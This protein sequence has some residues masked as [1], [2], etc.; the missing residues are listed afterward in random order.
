[1][2]QVPTPRAVTPS[3]RVEVPTSVG[4]SPAV[5][6]ASSKAS[7]VYAHVPKANTMTPEA[8]RTPPVT[9][10]ASPRTPVHAGQRGPSTPSSTVTSTSATRRPDTPVYSRPLGSAFPTPV[11]GGATPLR[12]PSLPIP[13]DSNSDTESSVTPSSLHSPGPIPSSSAQPTSSHILP[14]PGSTPVR[15]W[16]PA[17]PVAGNV[18]VRGWSPVAGTTPLRARLPVPPVAGNTPLRVRPPVA[19]VAG[20]APA[21]GRPPVVSVA[22]NTPVHGQSP[23]VSVAGDTPIR[24]RSPVIPG[25]GSYSA[26]YLRAIGQTKYANRAVE[27][28]YSQYPSSIWPEELAELLNIPL[29]QATDLAYMVMVD[30]DHQGLLPIE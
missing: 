23:A 15:G 19:P 7:S 9:P 25:F 6:R 17:V 14:V 21:Y 12:P 24:A 1:M 3:P 22:D 4:S 26:R 29:D 13:V 8:V 16:P 10:A 30:C 11:K 5:G 28:V 20:H 27:L 2:S 18:S